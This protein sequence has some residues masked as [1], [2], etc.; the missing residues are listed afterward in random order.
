MRTLAVWMILAAT[1]GAANDGFLFSFFRNNGEDGLYLATSG[2]G[3]TWTELHDGKPLL[4]PEVG[5]SKL[6]RDP[7][8]TAGPDG[9]FHMVWTTS[10]Q[11]RT[12]GY[13][14]SKDLIHWTAQR[15]LT[16]FGADSGDVENC[17]APELF[18]DSPSRMFWIVW[19][20]TKKG[21][22][23]ETAGTGSRDYNH[24]LY[25]M[26][27]RDFQTFTKPRVFYDPGFQVID[28]AVFRAGDGRYALIAKN[29][30]EKPVAAKNLFLAFA[31]K[32]EGP[33][34]K[35]GPP[36]SGSRWA[37]GPTPLKVGEY[38]YIYFDLYRD[39]KYGA[40]RSKNLLGW[41]DVT[42][43]LQMPA[44][45]KHGTVFPAPRAVIEGLS[46]P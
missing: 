19:A 46:K 37:E 17:W 35:A 39:H 32:L 2:D 24:R 15:E 10:W 43:R 23:A 13:S 9:T 34:S 36:I 3:L 14:S 40:I 7:S 27:T 28:G 25:A 29:E 33:W 16:P 11:G 44:G 22:F 18:Y 1:A 42:D 20:T 30:T 8:V 45:L 6:M 38:W 12:I 26:E 41:E 5:E 4:K 21:A 31:A